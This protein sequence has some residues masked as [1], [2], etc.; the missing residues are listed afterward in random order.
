MICAE[1]LLAQSGS[2]IVPKNAVLQAVTLERLR[3]FAQGA[4]VR[5]PV[6]VYAAAG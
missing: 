1:D 4:G 2:V 6:R 5:E 3:R